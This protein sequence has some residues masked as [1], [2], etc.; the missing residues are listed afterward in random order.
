MKS[1]TPQNTHSILFY[2][3]LNFH[4]HRGYMLTALSLPTLVQ[5]PPALCW[6]TTPWATLVKTISDHEHTYKTNTSKPSF[7]MD[8]I[9]R[10]SLCCV[11]PVLMYHP[12]SQWWFHERAAPNNVPRYLERRSKESSVLWF[13][14]K[15]LHIHSFTVS[16][17]SSILFRYSSLYDMNFHLQTFSLFLAKTC[18]LSFQF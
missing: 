10:L 4:Q 16:Y 1:N 5:S 3:H 14:C 6:T 18:Y 17:I 15:L 7:Y 9:I 12:H 13:M 8:L 11:F 2:T